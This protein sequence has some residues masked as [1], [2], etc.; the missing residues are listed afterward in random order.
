M[1]AIPNHAFIKKLPKE[2]FLT[3]YMQISIAKAEDKG[4]YASC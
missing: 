3:R 1:N 2:E 4:S